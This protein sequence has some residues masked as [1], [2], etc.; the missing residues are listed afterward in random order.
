M[1]F[2]FCILEIYFLHL[3]SVCVVLCVCVCL[4]VVAFNEIIICKSKAETEK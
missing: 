3:P 1:L 2:A 4:A